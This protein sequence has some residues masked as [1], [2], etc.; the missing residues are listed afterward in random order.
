[1]N[2]IELNALGAQ[3]MA[4]LARGGSA[5]ALRCFNAI[6]EAGRADGTV[7]VALALARQA[8]GDS[9]GTAHALD[10]ALKLEP[11][12]V[13]ALL[14]KGDLMADAGDR[15]AAV[16]FYGAALDLV[17][18]TQ[19]LPPEAISEMDRVRGARDRLNEALHADL[20]RGLLSRG[21]DPATA[22]PRFNESLDLLAGRKQ[23]YIQEPR[24]YF[25]P[26]LPT[27]QVYPRDSFPWL[28][29]IEAAT[30]DILAEL[31]AL[32]ADGPDIFAPY[33]EAEANRPAT[34]ADL[35]DDDTWTA[36]YLWRDGAPVPEIAARCP[37]TM[38]A[39]EHAP[40]ERIAGR[41]PFALFSRLTPGA[42]IA[43]HTGFHNSRLVVHLPLIAPRGC[44]FR[45]G[46]ETL[47]WETGKAFVFDDTI[48]HEAANES[49]E[50]RIVLIFNIWRPEL[51][52]A[53]R[54]LVAS[55]MEGIAGL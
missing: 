43:P 53:E 41:S 8:F 26:G 37:R 20:T 25:V 55:L 14:M 16:S 1:M 45:V 40:L 33:I 18:D 19:G 4:A 11:Q 50:T 51:T 34:Q 47:T 17:P 39:L 32:M 2:D 54:G 22:S 28:D 35:L 21:Y 24:S 42:V 9:G 15:R 31:Q 23:R 38:A 44:W 36:C 52:E 30:P 46:N 48:E 6:V 10:A 13:R 29:A 27:I 7:W 12:N 3:G 5:E 49:A